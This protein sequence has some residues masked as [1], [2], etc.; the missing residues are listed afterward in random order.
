[1]YKGSS[2][3]LNRRPEVRLPVAQG[4]WL[5]GDWDAQ[6][7]LEKRRRGSR[8]GACSLGVQEDQGCWDKARVYLV[9]THR[10]HNTLPASLR[11]LTLG[12]SGIPADRLCADS[13]QGC[14]RSGW[15]RGSTSRGV[16]SPR[17][18]QNL[19]DN[20]ER[21]GLHSGPWS[22]LASLLNGRERI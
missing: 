1:M 13:L 21:T 2:L 11:L 7:Y 16:H 15:V 19:L 6:R 5:A 14:T 10:G 17:S 12:C 3:V 18:E 4:G 20:V 22:N 9:C 8:A